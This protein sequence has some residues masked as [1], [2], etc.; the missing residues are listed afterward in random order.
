L[1]FGSTSTVWLA[2]NLQHVSFFQLLCLRQSGLM[3]N[4]EITTSS[5]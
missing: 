2:R 3:W 4:T 1:A 5:P